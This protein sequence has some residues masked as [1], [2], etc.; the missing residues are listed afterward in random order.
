MSEGWLHRAITAAVFALALWVRTE[1]LAARPMHA[2]EA[3]QAVK[4]GQM[5]DGAAYRFDPM[6]HHGPT[7]Y[8]A[9]WLV[10]S[11][12]GEASLRGL[13]ETTVRLVPA[14][15]GALSVVLLGLLLR[16][17]G[18]MASVAAML[19]L[20]ISPPAVYYSRYYIQ[21]SLLVAFTLGA[22]ASGRLWFVSGRATW[23]IAAGA[24]TGLMLATKASA[25]V[26]VIAAIAA[27]GFARRGVRLGHDRPRTFAALWPAAVVAMVVA[28]LFYSSFG[29]NLGGLADALATWSPMMARATG[30]AS[31]HEHAWWYYAGLFLFQ[32]RGGYVWDES[33]FLLLAAAGGVLAVRGR[34]GVER[35][36]A[37]Y[38][39]IVVL[40]LSSAPYKTPW[41]VVNAVPGMCVLAAVTVRRVPRK[42]GALLAA[43]VVGLLSW[44]MDRAVF[45][46]PADPRNPFAYSHSS[47]DVLKVVPMAAAA[48][49]G[50]VKV[51]STEYWPLPW[52]LRD[53]PEVGYWTSPPD[54]CDGAL[55]LVSADLA[56]A[57]RAKLRGSYR[58]SYLGLRPGFVLVAFVPR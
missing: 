18:Q 37:A 17:L 13:T 7:L 29:E 16:P 55:V 24:C 45:E 40:A 43:M 47:P 30:G 9:G 10:A 41:N 44:Q 14:V 53:R 58:S 12:R 2:D 26:Y 22:L 46:H 32:K 21:E 8:Y 56:E 54:D 50:P 25:A 35:F 57:V 34:S 33:S 20:A 15:F 52:Y 5:L 39:T 49:P 51:I 31:G 11:V 38:T 42:V 27:F 4:L 36:F 1:D 23:L 19:F 28:A 48:S 6:D 3:N